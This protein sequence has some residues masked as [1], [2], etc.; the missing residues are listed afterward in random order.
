MKLYYSPMSS[1]SQK[2]LVAFYEKGVEFTPS[3]VDLMDPAARAAYLEVNP[4][5]KVPLLRIEDKNWMVPESSI[6]IE[7]LDQNCAGPKMLPQDPEVARQ[8]RFRDRF[9]DFYLHEPM[10]KIFFDSMRPEGKKDPYGVELARDLLDRAYKSLNAGLER[11]KDKGPWAMGDTFTLADCAAAPA[12]NYLAMVH[13]YKSHE[14]LSAYASRLFER[15]S[16]KRVLKELEP[17]LAKMTKKN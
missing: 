3:V 6:I 1:Y 16:V 2:V 14:N 12:L 17:H 10:G 13:P 15:P 7:Y 5:G 4:L 11:M 9:C 8:V